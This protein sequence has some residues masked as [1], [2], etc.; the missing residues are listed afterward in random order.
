MCTPPV[1]IFTRQKA[2]RCSNKQ[3]GGVL[4]T[5]H[6]N[7]KLY[8]KGLENFVDI[9]LPPKSNVLVLVNGHAVN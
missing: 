6:M 5:G 1:I 2:F 7:I 3:I 4:E 8:L 9:K